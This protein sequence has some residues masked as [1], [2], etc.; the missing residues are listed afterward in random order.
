[1]KFL[2]EVKIFVQAGRGGNGC[3][4]FRREKFIPE[5]GP[6]GGNGGNGGDVIFEAVDNLNTLI[7]FRYTQHWRAK[8]GQNGMGSSCTGASGDDLIIR[9]PTGTVILSEDKSHEVADLTTSGQRF[10][11]ARGGR[12]G[13]G[14][15]SYKSSTNRAPREFEEGEAGEEAWLWLRLKLFADAGLVGLPNAGKST[16]LASVSRAKPKIADYPFTTLHPQLGVVTIGDGSFVLA[17]LPGL[18]AGASEGVG[19]GTR[20]LG[21]IERCRV[22]LHAIDATQDDVANAYHTIRRELIDYGYGVAA[23]PELVVLTKADAV[24]AERLA[25][26]T[27]ALKNECTSQIFV[28]SAVSGQGMKDILFAALSVIAA[29]RAVAEMP[30]PENNSPQSQG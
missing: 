3:V 22:L 11:I 1:M 4:A 6:N 28:V 24:T 16:F 5:G 21:H 19:L 20:F 17:D 25:E 8:S 13:R 2:D 29:A 14:N 18:I 9:V 23:K 15:E 7:D 30:Q 26:Q 12:G 10:T 27:A